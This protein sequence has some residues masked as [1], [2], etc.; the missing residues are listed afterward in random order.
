MKVDRFVTPLT[1]D[2]AKWQESPQPPCAFEMALW[3][4]F[5]GK[6]KEVMVTV[7][8]TVSFSTFYTRGQVCRPD[9]GNDVR[10][11][12]SVLFGFILESGKTLIDESYLSVN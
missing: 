9:L 12:G 8:R 4:A 2:A 11:F 3:K 10:L 6:V 1:L 5:V 7:S